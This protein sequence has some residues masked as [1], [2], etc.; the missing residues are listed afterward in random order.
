MTVTGIIDFSRIFL[1]CFKIYGQSTQDINDGPTKEAEGPYASQAAAVVKPNQ[2]IQPSQASVAYPVKGSDRQVSQ[3]CSGPN[4]V[5]LVGLNAR[6]GRNS[7]SRSFKNDNSAVNDVKSS[8]TALPSSKPDS[9]GQ[10]FG[11]RVVVKDQRKAHQTNKSEKSNCKQS[12]S[13]KQFASHQ[14]KPSGKT[15]ASLTSLVVW[16]QEVDI[17][18]YVE[19]KKIGSAEGGIDQGFIAEV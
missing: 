11:P 10:L 15:S 19:I 6:T 7:L 14:P 8:I 4:D 16:R 5:G 17:G 18:D 12:V 1:F 3:P 13:L 2:S 9:L